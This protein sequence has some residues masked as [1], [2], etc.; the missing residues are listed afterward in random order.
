VDVGEATAVL[1]AVT[2]KRVSVALTEV[3]VGDR[4]VSLGGG[5]SLETGTGVLTLPSAK[6]RLKPPRMIIS[7]TRA[8]RKPGTIWRKSRI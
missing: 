5:V 3:F 4:G 1:V 8:I 2:G 6:E 7:E